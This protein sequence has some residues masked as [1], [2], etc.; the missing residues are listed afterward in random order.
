MKTSTYKKLTR[1]EYKDLER[2]DEARLKRS[3]AG[4]KKRLSK[5]LRRMKV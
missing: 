1:Q 3:I 5:H 2:Y 4:R